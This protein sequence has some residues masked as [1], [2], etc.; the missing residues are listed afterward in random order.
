MPR[1]LLVLFALPVL[2]VP[3]VAQASLSTA[4]AAEAAFAVE[5]RVVDMR[6][7]GVPAARVTVVAW[8]APDNVLVKTVADGD[9][10][11]RLGSVPQLPALQIR[12]V[13][14]GTCVGVTG[15]NSTMRTVTIDVQHATTVRGIL[16]NKKG[17]PV[18]RAIVRAH[19]WGRCLTYVSSDARTGDDGRFEIT[20]VPL[21]LV[22]FA[23]WIDGEGLAAVVQHV[24]G[25]CEIVLAPDESKT[26]RLAVNIAGLPA[27]APPIRLSVL[28][29]RNGSLSYL[30]PPH[31]QPLVDSRGSWT[32]DPAPDCDYTIYPTA[33]GFV[34]A[35]RELQVK[36]GTGPHTLAFTAT[37]RGATTLVI[38]VVVR[39]TEDKPVAGL[40][41]TMRAPNGGTA[42]TA[43]SAS[44]GSLTFPSPLAAGTAAVIYTTHEQWVVDQ[45]K[46][47]TASHDRR[48]LTQYEFLVDATQPLALRVVPACSVHGRLL[49]AD[50]RP[51]AFVRVELQESSSRRWPQ[52]MAMSWATSDREGGLRFVGR[53]HLGDPVRLYVESRHGS[54]VGEPFQLAS[55]GAEHRPGEMQLAA[56]ASIDGVVRDAEQ[57]PVP[58]LRVWLRDWDLEKNGQ[59]SGSVGETLTDRDGRYRFVGVPLGGAYL[60]LLSGTSERGVSDRAV[61]P[62]EVEAGKTYTFDL[63]A[64]SK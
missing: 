62:F 26:T 28:P 64:P 50:G 49:Q 24:S 34:F 27:K 40:P 59:A 23:A 19:P 63:Q 32:A 3:V 38:K 10:Y 58:G 47:A 57:R 12:G 39:D 61:E 56:P 54:F 2:L 16:R 55:A 31:D 6:G 43:T 37:P 45:T 41:F 53:H 13:G 4:A 30:P 7:D 11:F 25:P 33:E 35:P 18:P 52:W 1:S 8:S 14:E 51:A 60:Q 36:A 44:D 48:A 5:G 15:V 21:A 46:S 17:E 42:V 9:G 20:A 29:Y 22:Q